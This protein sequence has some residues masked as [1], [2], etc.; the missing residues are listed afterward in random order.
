LYRIQCRRPRQVRVWDRTLTKLRNINIGDENN[1]LEQPT[2]KESE[3]THLNEYPNCIM[4]SQNT[5]YLPF[6][7]YVPFSTRHHTVWRYQKADSYTHKYSHVYT[8]G[9]YT[10]SQVDWLIDWC[11]TIRQHRK[12]NLCQLRGGKPAKSAMDGQRDTMHIT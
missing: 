11:L 10:W 3:Q 1:Q 5:K 12:V 9:V 4:P 6:T 8:K 2:V 7:M